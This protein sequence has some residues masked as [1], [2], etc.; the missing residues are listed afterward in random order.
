METAVRTAK[1]SLLP[2][3]SF[4]SIARS[5]TKINW[6][7]RSGST[8]GRSWPIIA[9]RAC[10]VSSLGKRLKKS[11]SSTFINIDATAFTSCAWESKPIEG[12]VQL[13]VRG[14]HVSNLSGSQT[15]LGDEESSTIGAELGLMSCEGP[16]ST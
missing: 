13:L 7:M 8:V 14:Q 3:P 10:V 1:R 15:Y 9:F 12:A 2:H 6:A 4:D 11:P 5:H 16:Q